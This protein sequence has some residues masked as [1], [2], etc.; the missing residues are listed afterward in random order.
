VAILPFGRRWR[1]VGG[2]PAFSVTGMAVKVVQR[3]GPAEQGG[4]GELVPVTG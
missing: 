3:A 4:G 1:T 2:R